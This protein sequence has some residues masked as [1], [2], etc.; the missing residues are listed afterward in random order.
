[1]EF[2]LILPKNIRNKNIIQLLDEVWLIPKKQRHFLRMKKHL[3]INGEIS[4]FNENVSTGDQIT[5]IFDLDEDFPKHD[6]L[7]GN[8]N[9]ANILY[10]DEHLVIAN[11]PEGMKTHPNEAGEIALQNH[12]AAYCKHPVYVVHRLDQDT[13]GAVLFAKNQF[14]LPMLGRMF[15]TNKI[16]REYL[17][18]VE[19]QLV[20]KQFTINKSIGRDRH[21]K[22]RRL[23][24]PTGQS[25]ITHV[26]LEA[27]LQKTSLVSCLLDTGRT[28]QI[29]VHLASINHPL[30]GDRLYNNKKTSNLNQKETR[31]MLHAHKISFVHPLTAEKLEI[32]AASRTF[33]ERYKQ[34]H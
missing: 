4:R 9:L 5:F 21:N 18:L 22:S 31:M 34:E 12:I 26:K 13:S 33:D 8:K 2:T 29:R 3:L 7:F 23:V 32:S 17:A 20:T 15:E 19:G 16:H 27:T 24:S 28:H 30:V 10:E 25:A 14:I 11:K 1:M 6:C